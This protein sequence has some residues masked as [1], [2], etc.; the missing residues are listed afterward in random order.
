MGDSDGPRPFSGAAA[1]DELRLRRSRAILSTA[2][3][4]V[5]ADGYE[6]LTMQRIA[7]DLECGVATLYRLFPSKDALIGELQLDALDLLGASWNAG[8][9]HLDAALAAAQLP[10]R[11]RALTR[12]LAAGWFWVVAEGRFPHEVELSRRIVVDQVA[13]VVPEE[14][15]ARILAACLAL[16][17][18]GRVRLEAA[19]EHGALDPGNSGERA[20]V[21]ISTIFGIAVT[22]NGARWELQVIDRDRVAREAVAGHLVA[23][24][25]DRAA[26][27]AAAAVLEAELAEGWLVP[28]VE[29][30]GGPA[31]G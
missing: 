26:V 29:R 2:L 22:A 20:I 9:A 3:G 28:A 1:R 14:Q 21:L 25:A 11:D 31:P 15:S 24:G 18:Q 10:E 13:T 12:A 8:L 6:A 5:T 4:I 19:V 17:D 23:W 7:D 30:P 16:F 27:A